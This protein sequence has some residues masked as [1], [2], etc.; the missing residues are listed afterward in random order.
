MNEKK[1]QLITDF[2]ACLKNYFNLRGEEIPW[3]WILASKADLSEQ[4]F[5]IFQMIVEQ[6]EMTL[7]QL[8]R[9]GF[10]YQALLQELTFLELKKRIEEFQPGRYRKKLG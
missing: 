6:W 2:D 3:A 1:I 5:Q 4:Q 10:S 9:N 8:M 7:E